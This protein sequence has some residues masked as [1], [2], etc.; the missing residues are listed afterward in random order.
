MEAMGSGTTVI[1]SAIPGCT[2][3]VED[4]RTGILFECGD[5]AALA[6]AMQLVADDAELRHELAAAG[7]TLVNERYSASAMASNYTRL[8]TEIC[9][10]VLQVSATNAELKSQ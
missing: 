5:S 7:K 10:D 3:L 6:E 2:D 4:G 1:A 8:Y 9:G